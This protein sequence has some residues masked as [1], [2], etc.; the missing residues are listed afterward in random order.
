MGVR[1][2]V[3]AFAGA[4]ADI[5][6]FEW[7]RFREVGVEHK[8]AMGAEELNAL[9]AVPWPDRG[10]VLEASPKD[11][12]AEN[13]SLGGFSRVPSNISVSKYR[14]HRSGWEAG[15]DGGEKGPVRLR[16]MIWFGFIRGMMI[17]EDA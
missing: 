8:K 17:N 5:C 2:R 12:G 4:R 14:E 6:S 13:I 15:D 11:V 7:G 10:E 3:A 9:N 16:D 1:V